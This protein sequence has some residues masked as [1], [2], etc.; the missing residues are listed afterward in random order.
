MRIPHE[1]GYAAGPFGQL[2]YMVCGTGIPL[3]LVHQ[4]PDSMVQFVPVMEFLGRH[5]K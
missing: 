2:H 1:K 5:G 3:V 4:C